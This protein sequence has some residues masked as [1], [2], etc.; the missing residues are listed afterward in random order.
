MANLLQMS[1]PLEYSHHAMLE[2]ISATMDSL[3]VPPIWPTPWMSLLLPILQLRVS[4]R[5]RFRREFNIASSWKEDP[6][7]D[8]FHKYLFLTVYLYSRGNW[9]A[10]DLHVSLP[11]FRFLMKKNV[12]CSY[13]ERDLQG[14]QCPLMRLML[15][16][17]PL[18][19]L[20]DLSENSWRQLSFSL[21][22]FFSHMSN[23]FSIV[24]VHLWEN[25]QLNL[26]VEYH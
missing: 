23:V 8:F 25:T 7:W 19:W 11:L 17:K 16:K 20:K 12:Q 4:R 15:I 6:V 21:N 22:L 14:Y 9:D 26:F 18:A 10:L 3:S 24:I 1:P 2:T 5:H 13:L